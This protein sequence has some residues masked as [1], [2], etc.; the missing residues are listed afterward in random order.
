VG[1]GIRG[2]EKEEEKKKIGMGRRVGG[3]GERKMHVC[4]CMCSDL[5]PFSY[6]ASRN[7]TLIRISNL[8]HFPKVPLVLCFYLLNFTVGIKFQSLGD[9]QIIFKP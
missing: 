4:V 7:S 8:N 5:S 3:K 9:T 1:K 2:D 6:K